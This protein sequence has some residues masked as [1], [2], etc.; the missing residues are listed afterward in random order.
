MLDRTIAPEIKNAVDFNLQLPPYEKLILDNGVEVNAINMGVEDV[1]QLGLVFEAG[2]SWEQQNLVASATNRLLKNGTSQKTAFE[3]NEDVDFY[4]S[5]LDLTCG[6]ETATINL[7]TL[8]K[9]L[10]ALL[11]LINEM[12]TDAT[13]SEE[14]INTFKQ[15]RKQKLSVNLKKCAFVAGRLIDAKLY[16]EEHPYGKYSRMEDRK[17]VV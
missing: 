13:F 7:H 2:N 3:F 1:M 17:S 16:G 5:F 12:I 9:N 11:P 6:N 15:N 8:S 4:G 10:S 14:E